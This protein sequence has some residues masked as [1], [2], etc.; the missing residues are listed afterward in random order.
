MKLCELTVIIAIG[1]RSDRSRPYPTAR[2]PGSQSV[3]TELGSFLCCPYFCLGTGGPGLLLQRTRFTLPI[4]RA[5]DWR[6]LWTTS[7][8]VQRSSANDT[9]SIQDIIRKCLGGPVIVLDGGETSGEDR[10]WFLDTDIGEVGVV[11]ERRYVC[12][13]PSS[14]ELTMIQILL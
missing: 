2:S 13:L 6:N 7:L 3:E 11:L 14:L 4:S 8:I 10:L 1:R 12:A 9:G 5:L